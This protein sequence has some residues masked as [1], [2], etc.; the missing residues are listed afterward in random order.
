[1]PGEIE[2]GGTHI[3]GNAHRLNYSNG[4]TFRIQAATWEW[5]ENAALIRHGSDPFS[6]WIFRIDQYANQFDARDC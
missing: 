5:H 2:D 4:L 3:F 1:V 6:T